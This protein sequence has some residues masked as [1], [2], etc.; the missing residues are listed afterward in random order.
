MTTRAAGLTGSDVIAT[1]QRHFEAL[2]ATEVA[3]PRYEVANVPHVIEISDEDY[4]SFCFPCHALEDT[5]NDNDG[6]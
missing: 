6:V 5:E 4:R 3:E 1:A 2:P